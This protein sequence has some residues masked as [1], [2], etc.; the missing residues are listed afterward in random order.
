MN[1]DPKSLSSASKCYCMS[2]KQARAVWVYLLCQWAV[3][4]VVSCANLQGAGNPT[5][6]STGTG[7]AVECVNLS[8]TGSP[9]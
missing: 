4:S 2:R 5:S 1:C 3:R 6:I 8:G 7:V 9:V